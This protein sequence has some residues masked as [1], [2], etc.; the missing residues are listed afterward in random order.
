MTT[1]FYR[2]T[3]RGKADYFTSSVMLKEKVKKLCDVVTGQQVALHMKEIALKD[4]TW[5]E[6]GRAYFDLLEGF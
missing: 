6:I 4:Y 2:F 1:T 5:A 3:T